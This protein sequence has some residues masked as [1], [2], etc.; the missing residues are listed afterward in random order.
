MH[1][2]CT[3]S[4]GFNQC[5][6]ERTPPQ[7][8]LSPPL[9]HGGRKGGM[10]GCVRVR[11]CV[12]RARREVGGAGSG[13]SAPPSCCRAP[14]RRGRQAG[15]PN[16]AAGPRWG[17]ATKAAGG[18]RGGGGPARLPTSGCAPHVLRPSR[19]TVTVCASLGPSSSLA[20]HC[21][22][23]VLGPRFIQGQ[24]QGPISCPKEGASGPRGLGQPGGWEDSTGR[25]SAA[26]R[27]PSGS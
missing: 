4:T 18:V 1:G 25:S 24:L 3:D 5:L 6:P 19:P 8:R 9:E 17:L 12:V 11:V 7:R 23:G 21:P 10:G 15:R 27:G 16:G 26:P 14:A 20:S 22:H 2:A 13:G